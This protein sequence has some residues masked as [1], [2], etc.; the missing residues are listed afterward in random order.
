MTWNRIHTLHRGS[1]SADQLLAVK[2]AGLES[3][4]H[5]RNQDPDMEA[6]AAFESNLSSRMILLHYSL[7]QANLLYA[8]KEEMRGRNHW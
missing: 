2:T 8:R 7:I 6:V 4:S 3:V 1:Y 5:Q